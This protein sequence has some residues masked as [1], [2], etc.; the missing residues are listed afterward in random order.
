MAFGHAI[1]AGADPLALQQ[2]PGALVEGVPTAKAVV[3]MAARGQRVELP[4]CQAV[5]AILDGR[6][7]VER[8]VE[9]ADDQA[10]EGG[11]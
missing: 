6:L 3:R 1:G 11:K 2:A 9:D 7:E 5:D 8:A 10:A 4:I